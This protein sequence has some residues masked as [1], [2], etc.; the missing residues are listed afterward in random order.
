MSEENKGFSL[1][2]LFSK[3]SKENCKAAYSP[4]TCQVIHNPAQNPRG[5]YLLIF[6]SNTPSK[7]RK[8]DF[9][10]RGL[11]YNKLNLKYLRG[12]YLDAINGK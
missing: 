1:N 12:L 2:I 4:Q 5:V 9:F 3:N 6:S 7:L 10:V 8:F 11:F